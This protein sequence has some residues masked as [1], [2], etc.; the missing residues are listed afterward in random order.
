MGRKVFISILGTS[1]Y[2]KSVYERENPCFTAK[3]TRFIQLATLELLKAEEWDKENSLIVIGLTEGARTS[4]WNLSTAEKP[5]QRIIPNPNKGIKEWEEYIG[6][7][8]ELQSL[9][10]NIPV[11]ECSIPDG[12]NEDEIM[13]IFSRLFS[14]IK[15]GDELHFDLTHGFRYLP[16]LVTVLA[17]YS[18]FIYPEVTIEHMSYGNFEMKNKNGNCTFIDLLPL[19]TLQ[20]WTFAAGQYEKSGNVDQIVSLSEGKL[21]QLLRIGHENKRDTTQE[22]NLKNFVLSLSNVIEDLRTCRGINIVSGSCI[23]TMREYEAK[24]DGISIKQLEPILNKISKDLSRF[25]ESPDTNNGFAAAKWC[26]EKHLYQQSI[27]ILKENI[28]TLL[29]LQEHLDWKSEKERGIIESALFYHSPKSKDESEIRIIVEPQFETAFNKAINNELLKRV[30]N[31]MAS[32]KKVRNDYNHSGIRDDYKHADKIIKEIRKKINNIDELFK[33]SFTFPLD[34]IPHIFINLSNHP[35]SRWSEEQMSA[36]REYGDII[37]MPFPKV[38]DFCGEDDILK[39]V[40]KYCKDILL[41]THGRTQNIVVHIMGEMTFTYAMVK[42]LTLMGITCVASTTERITEEL[43][44][45]SK[46]VKFEFCRFRR[47]E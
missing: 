4:N 22:K 16:M 14:F 20:E 21:N 11:A 39:L 7:K 37:D 15:E 45:G 18:R 40:D 6:L 33:E 31:Y 24:V 41:E 30:A 43:P 32:I 26:F 36:A 46:N 29:C 35:S 13:E 47:Y 2:R 5:N 28:V 10:P 9:F 27:T 38:D 23:K 3:E 25:V 8:E 12:K 44:D 19:H 1:F 42:E 17:N 34:D